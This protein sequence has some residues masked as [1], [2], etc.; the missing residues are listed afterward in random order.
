[1]GEFDAAFEDLARSAPDAAPP[2]S[3][4]ER[5]EAAIDE[6]EIPGVETMR[7]HDGDWHLRGNGVWQKLLMDSPDGKRI[8]M[9]RCEPGAVITG[10]TH[11]G[12]EYALVIEGRFQ[13]EGTTVRAG[14][15]Q[16]S[17]ANSFHPEITTDT[18]CLLLVV[19]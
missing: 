12:W 9:L 13:I 5:I 18:G 6:P 4:F 10:H 16:Y 7:A 3:L 2:E 17:A 1:M 11:K 15:S 14:D 8:F 19:A